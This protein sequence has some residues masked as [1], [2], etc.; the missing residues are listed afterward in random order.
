MRIL[1][2]QSRSHPFIGG[3]ESHCFQSAMRLVKMGHSVDILTTDSLT[4][5]VPKEEIIEGVKIIRKHAWFCIPGTRL[6]IA[7]SIYF[8]SMD[9]YDIV[10]SFGCIPL[11]S[12]IMFWIAKKRGKR[13][14]LSHLFD[15]IGGDLLFK[16]R[17][18]ILYKHLLFN[19]CVKKDDIITTLT[20][21]Y[22]DNSM[23]IGGFKNVNVLTSGVDPRFQCYSPEKKIRLRESKNLGDRKVI[24][25]VGRL[26]AYKGTKYLIDAM[27]LI[28]TERAVLLIVGKGDK[29]AALKEQAKDDPQH[30][31]FI[32]GLTDK[33]LVEIYNLAD[34][35]VFPSVSPQ[36][37]FGKVLTEAM[38]CGVPIIATDLI[39][40]REVAQDCG[41][42]VPQKDP[43]ALADAIDKMLDENN[44]YMRGDFIL[45]GF[46]KAA[47]IYDWDAITKKR[48]ELYGRLKA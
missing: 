35:F 41:F 31:K 21:D 22:A 12:D 23:F 44:Q 7:P 9:G 15:P 20:Q 26:D 40:V 14:I 46:R 45:N 18:C 32:E 6:P 34:V 19:R 48:L 16:T 8:H 42:V 29:S 4:L 24:L 25:T 13:A 38:T 10:E 36:E 43:Q 17:V 39:G 5:N 33:E 1:F 27:K 47:G 11:V 28:K 3:Y 30:I 2:I 37:V